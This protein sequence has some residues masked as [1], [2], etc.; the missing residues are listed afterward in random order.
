LDDDGFG[1]GFAALGGDGFG[2]VGG[3]AVV[4]GHAAA[5][6]GELQCGGGADA[7]GGAGDEGDFVFEI[8]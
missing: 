5:G 1:S 2:A 7:A 4:N 6:L 8:H 3:L